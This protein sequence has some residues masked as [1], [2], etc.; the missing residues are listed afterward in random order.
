M[1]ISWTANYRSRF[2]GTLH[3]RGHGG[4]QGD[5]LAHVVDIFPCVSLCPLWLAFAVTI[6]NQAR[7]R[8]RKRMSSPDHMM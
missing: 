3:H 5:L 1:D 4:T 6:K 7:S 8:K 2:S